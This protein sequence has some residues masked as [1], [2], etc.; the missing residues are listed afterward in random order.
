MLVNFVEIQ[1]SA[2]FFPTR[3]RYVLHPSRNYC[4]L[5][6]SCGGGLQFASIFETAL[7]VVG[8]APMKA[9]WIIKNVQNHVCLPESGS[10]ALKMKNALD[11]RVHAPAKVGYSSQ[12]IHILLLRFLISLQDACQ[13]LFNINPEENLQKRNSKTAPGNSM[14]F[15]FPLLFPHIKQFIDFNCAC[16]RQRSLANL[17]TIFIISQVSLLAKHT[18][19]SSLNIL[20]ISP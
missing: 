15:F 16:L 10:T 13:G 5:W 17:K 14:L 4:L 19:P 12:Q 2:W 9:F 7:H 8:S 1:F 18:F 3:D 20:L 6:A 11:Q